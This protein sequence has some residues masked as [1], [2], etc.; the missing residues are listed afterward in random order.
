MVKLGSVIA[1]AAVAAVV[2]PGQTFTTLVRFDGAHGSL[3]TSG[4]MQ[5]LDGSLYGTTNGGGPNYGGTVFSLAL[6][7]TLTTVY[8]FANNG[9]GNP[10]G[11][12][13]Q[14][15]SGE[16]FGTTPG[17]SLPANPDGTIFEL[18]VNGKF[19]TLHT[20]NYSDGAHPSAPL[21]EAING[22][23]YG[24][25]IGEFDANYYGS[26]FKITP[27]GE[28]TNLHTFTGV[29]GSQ[30]DSRL[31]Q[32]ADGY[33]YGTTPQ[34]GSTASGGAGG[35]GTI[36]RITP[37]GEFTSLYSFC[38]APNCPDGAEPAGGLIEGPQGVFYGTT[39]AGGT[40]P[41]FDNG[42]VFKYQPGGSAVVIHNFCVAWPDCSDGSYPYGLVRGTDGNFYGV[43]AYGGTGGR[44]L[45]TVFRITPDGKLTTL[46]TF[47]TQPGCP[48]GRYPAYTLLQATDGN[49][50]G[51]TTAGGNGDNGTI[52]RLNMGLAPFITTVPTSCAPGR[53]VGIVGP[54][55]A[56][57]T[58]VTF[59]GRPAAF[60]VAS[61]HLILATVPAGATS[62]E[63]QVVTP[64][65][66]LRG[67]LPFIVR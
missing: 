27:S 58:S 4:L 23:L 14:T 16:I 31:L 5:G 25:T 11:G 50:Y 60:T 55:M 41:T 24:T 49:F 48:D 7:S 15:L 9:K 32:T 38:T 21:I 62:G 28:F 3:P 22:D 33:L 57:S 59:N 61:H 19:A 12:L 40:S 29:D 37:A 67:N 13:L 34:G 63:V 51:V 20:F 53:Q 39:T 52:F 17:D 6:D 36:F 45:G 65:G 54:E 1:T 8:G 42:T 43:T 26:I 10:S 66:V 56:G 2:L 64:Q 35:Q 46:H 18:T 47:C 30:P 44:Y